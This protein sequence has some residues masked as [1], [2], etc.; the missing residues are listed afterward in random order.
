LFAIT[1]YRENPMEA[2]APPTDSRRRNVLP[3]AMG[4]ALLLI[5]PAL[6]VPAAAVEAQ[7]GAGTVRLLVEAQA[8]PAAG[9]EVRAGALRTRT[10]AEGQA[11]LRLPAGLHTISVRLAGHASRSLRVAV[12]EGMDSTLVV[13][14]EAEAIALEGIVVASTRTGRRIEDE[15]VRVE[16]LDREEIEEKMLMT[17]GDIAM[18][19]NETSGLRVQTTSPSLGGANV[20]IQGLRGR[21]TQIL[22]DGLPL[23]GGQSGALSMLQIPPM[24]LAQ[25]EVIKGVA[26][27][28]YGASAMGGVVN[29]ISRRPADDRELLLNQTTRGG[30]DGVLWAT[31]ELSDQWGYTFLGGAHRQGMHDVSGDG[32]A[33]LAGYQR[34]VVRPRL[35]WNDGAGRSLFVTVGGTLESREGGTLPGAT[36][37]AGTDYAEA[38]DTRRVDVG[39]LGRLLVAGDRLLTVRASAMGQRHD[40]RFGAARER[41]LHTTGFGE[42]AITG[43][44]RGHTWVAGAALQHEGYAARDVAGF[45]YRHTTPSLFVQD[46]LSPTGWLTIAASGRVDAHSEFGAVFNPRISV[47]LRP[48]G[49]WSVRASV[50]TGYFA[51]TPF[52]EETEVF[53]LARVE[54]LHGLRIE[55]ARSGSLDLGRTM[56]HVELNGTLFGSEVDHPL[57]LR[58]IGDGR[59]ELFNAAEPTRTWGTDLLARFHEEPFHLVAT[60]TYTR[61][62]ELDPA[63]GARRV[64]P[65]TPRHA[66]GAVGMWEAEEEAGRVGVELYYTG[67]QPLEDNPYRPESRPYLILGV[68]VERRVGS[69]RVFLNAENLLD[70][71]QTRWDP[72]LLPARS[73]E[74]RWTTDAWAPL[75]GRTLNAGVRL[76]F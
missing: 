56:G 1:L 35:F 21:Y 49:E 53:G 12:T 18:M 36:T 41:D 58:R 76:E 22:S 62:T 24:D 40:H 25:V 50:G 7:E 65:L 28:L 57:M 4:L 45:D 72:L 51:P 38:L 26:S 59:V 54:P 63:G 66:A 6:L 60:Y 71:R 27:A 43:T 13:V 17:P 44:D 11:L 52:T 61:S 19:L 55:R 3:S 64:V 14:L 73:P 74:G 46:E 2:A 33:D 20:R 70:A 8:A 23:Y 16:V 75:E 31:G 34:A 32:W 39:V 48:E 68:L 29:L 69:A 30:T 5:V 15:P 42:V 37:P 47:L 9:A 10:D 67:R